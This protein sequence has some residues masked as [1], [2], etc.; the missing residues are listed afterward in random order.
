MQ[1]NAALEAVKA[2]QN[3]IRDAVAFIV[4]QRRYRFS[5]RE[6]EIAL[7]AAESDDLMA[8]GRQIEYLMMRVPMSGGGDSYRMACRLEDA[9]T[10]LV[11]LR[12]GRDH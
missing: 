4:A 1:T 10:A 5:A 12:F 11:A 2:A 7:A 6:Q 3:T 8:L 9:R